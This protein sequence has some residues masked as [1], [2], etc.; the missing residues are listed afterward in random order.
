MGYHHA[1][2]S[3]VYGWVAE[4]DNPEDLI[5][6]ALKATEAG[7]TK[8]DAYSPFP[9]DGLSEA[10]GMHDVRVKWIIF[11]GGLAGVSAGM[12]L[13]YYTSAVDYPLNVG[14][15]PLFSWPS[16]IPVAFECTVLIAALAAVFG[17]LALNKLPE[18][19]HAIFNTPNFERASQDRFFLCI[20]ADDPQFEGAEKF[21]A[22]L[23]AITVSEVEK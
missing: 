1:A 8:L 16:F 21:V 12:G 13:M 6:A 22:G 10:I 17:M 18:P 23:G 11:L 5:V 4:F 20:E 2:E 19:Y 15:R 9:V 14:G 3:E 7:Y